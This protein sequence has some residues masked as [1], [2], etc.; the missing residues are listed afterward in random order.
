MELEA[1][2]LMVFKAALYDKG[3]PCGAGERAIP[4]GRGLFPCLRDGCLTVEWDTRGVPSNAIA[5]G[6]DPAPCAG[7]PQLILCFIAR[8]LG[9]PKSY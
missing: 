5:R 9:L 3:E 8:R 1:A 4:G 7:E 6:D 2:N